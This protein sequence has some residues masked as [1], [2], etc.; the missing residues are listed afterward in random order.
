MKETYSSAE[1]SVIA[2]I[3]AKAKENTDVFTVL[4]PKHFTYMPFADIYKAACDLNSQ[5]KDVDIVTMEGIIGKE[6]R[7]LIVEC[8]ELA[9]TVSEVAKYANDIIDEYDKRE[10]IASL[11]DIALNSSIP[12]IRA[13]DIVQDV[14]KILREYVDYQVKRSEQTAKGFTDSVIEFIEMM[15]KQIKT[16]YK[17]GYSTLDYFL[18]GLQK[19]S[20]NVI[21]AAS[22]KGKTDFAINLALRLA[23]NKHKVLY[24]SMEMPRT[25]LI[26]RIA[27]CITQIDSA[28]IRDK[29]LT[30][31]QSSMIVQA[32]SA[33]TKTSNIIFDEQ[34]TLTT[35]DL[36]AKIDR[37]KPDICIVDHLGLMNHQTSGKVQQ[38]EG[39]MKTSQQLK[40]ISM[41]T[42][43]AI[44]E[45]VQTDIPKNQSNQAPNLAWLRGGQSIGHDADTVLFVIPKI[46]PG[47]ILRGNQSAETI[48]SIAK[49]RHGKTGEIKF[50]WYP[51]YHKYIEKDEIH[52]EV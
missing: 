22:G 1:A 21:S 46:S 30:K 14:F 51:Q 20:I 7:A 29:N 4:S 3:I 34:G 47:D 17:M 38:W 11:T 12:V 15:D 49:N 39:V 33:I 45:L 41:Q 44:I 2:G 43:T 32:L 35:D 27:S 28:S 18:G 52:K 16:S 31:E 5:G 36:N 37:Y 13:G 9:P 48:V 19:G 8:I 24:L 6:Y 25:Q 50:N 26:T 10:I 40:K 42:K 23:K